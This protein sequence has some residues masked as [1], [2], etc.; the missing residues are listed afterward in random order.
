MII[1]FW[2]GIALGWLT[3]RAWTKSMRDVDKVM[4][5][6]EIDFMAGENK[7]LQEQVA[8]WIGK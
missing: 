1:T 6:K 4:H 5:K 8:K 3:C 2:I 7:R